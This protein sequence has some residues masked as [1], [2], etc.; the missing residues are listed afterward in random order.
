M[1]AKLDKRGAR[2]LFWICWAVYFC[3]YLGRLNYSSV[4]NELI[5]PVLTKA[6]AGWVNTAF[7]IAYAVGQLVNGI[8]AEKVSPHW[9]AAA[10]AMGSGLV[11]IL[12]ACA[13]SFWSM[14]LLRLLT[15]FFMSM[16]WPSIL[17]AMVR[18]MQQ[19]DKIHGTV[20]ITS[21]MAAGTL[22]SYALSA[23]L[24]RWFPWGS[25]FLV[26]GGLLILSGLLW[27]IKYPGIARTAIVPEKEFNAVPRAD[28]P[29]MPL[30]EL[31]VIPAFFIAIVPAILHGA[32]KDGVTAWVPTYVCEVFGKSTSFS[33][34]VSA[35]LPLFNLTGAYLAQYAYK[36]AEENTFKGSAAFF[37][38]AALVLVFM[39]T[40]GKGN[41]LLTMLC[42]A[43]ITSSMMAVNVLLINLLP[44]Q[45]G[46][47]G[48]SAT[49]SGCLNA[50]AYGGSALASGMIGVLSSAYGWNA[51]VASWLILMVLGC[52]LC[53]VGRRATLERRDSEC[54][55]S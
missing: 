19:D 13:R 33:A 53:A 49:V 2:Q 1:N 44:L 4:M 14:L 47:Y 28:G 36:K 10:G 43:I 42:F 7:L 26:P 5:G 11:N 24:L 51:T 17:C 31:M 6:Q 39:L 37:G 41:L 35:L 40:A 29:A 48:R 3:S 34:L 12:F 8:V 52:I 50:I 38:L 54:T 9:F 45:F 22:V 16:L 27:L 55:L 23:V 32:I 46:E 25:A 20:N 30:T 15:G 18:L 21:S